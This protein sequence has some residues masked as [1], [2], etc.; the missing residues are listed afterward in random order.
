MRVS[1][2]MRVDR[3]QK[4]GQYRRQDAFD[5]WRRIS[6]ETDGALE[7][8]KQVLARVGAQQ[9]E[10]ASCLIFAVAL[11]AQ[12]A[13]EEAAGR[14]AQFAKTLAQERQVF[15][16][17]V[18]RPMSPVHAPLLAGA[19]REQTMAGA[20]GDGGAVDDDFFFSDA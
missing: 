8:G 13:V 6:A 3:G 5:C 1:W 16:R 4:A 17:V 15:R 11:I 10:Y 20:L 9:S 18:A 2:F 14:R 7:G 19:A 12:H